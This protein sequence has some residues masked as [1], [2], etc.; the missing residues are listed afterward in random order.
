[1]CQVASIK[2]AGPLSSSRCHKCKSTHSIA[3]LV[4][5]APDQP[6]QAAAG[7]LGM[8][9]RQPLADISLQ[10]K[11]RMPPQLCGDQRSEQQCDQQ[12][13][14]RQH[15]EKGPLAVVISPHT[16]AAYCACDK[17]PPQIVQQLA[18]G[19]STAEASVKLEQPSRTVKVEQPSRTRKLP[20]SL[21]HAPLAQL[22]QLSLKKVYPRCAPCVGV[23]RHQSTEHNVSCA[24]IEALPVSFPGTRVIPGLHRP[25]LCAVTRV[26]EHSSA[27]HFAIQSWRRNAC[28]ARGS[29]RTFGGC[30]CSAG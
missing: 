6:V 29:G 30:W 28:S 15:L 14:K 4:V 26:T 2:V 27:S 22:P 12:Q 20:A 25:L 9:Q 3:H 24:C 5:S 16:T 10:Q 19:H 17:K 8:A 18:A 13:P 11:R 7:W 1:M 21:S 23:C